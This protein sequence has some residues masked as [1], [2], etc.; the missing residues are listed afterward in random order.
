[1]IGDV[2]QFVDTFYRF[3]IVGRTKQ[4]INLKGEEVMED[5]IDTI[6]HHI[7]QEF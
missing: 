2:I 6:I 1:M 3:H 4:C 5:Q 7:N